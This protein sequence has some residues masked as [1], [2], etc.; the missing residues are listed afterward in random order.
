MKC[1]KW[2]TGL[3]EAEISFLLFYISAVAGMALPR[4]SFALSL[5]AQTGFRSNC[6][7]RGESVIFPYP[8]NQQLLV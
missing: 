4:N 3:N 2:C 6:E 7:I 5:M 1:C 8:A